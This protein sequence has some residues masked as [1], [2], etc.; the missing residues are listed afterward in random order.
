MTLGGRSAG[1][2]GAPADPSA[3]GGL[4]ARLVV[5]R[6]SFLLDIE[7]SVA[8]GEVVA[9]LG[10]NG[11]GKTTAL[12]ALAG[13]T[14]L[15]SGRVE[16]AGVCLDDGDRIF[17]PAERRSVGV[18]FQDYLLFPHLS[19]LENVAFGPRCRGAT[20]VASRATAQAWLSRVG[21][22][23]LARRRPRQLSGG[24]AQRV[25][26]ARALALEP[27][28]L[29]LDEPLA[30]LDARTR[31]DT[32]AEL[33]RHLAEHP[34]P[35]LVVTHEPLDAFVLADRLVI[36]EDGRIVQEGDAAEV[37]ARPRTDY[38]ARLVGLNLYRGR[39]DG[40]TVTLPTGTQLTAAD[41]V[42]GDAF[43]A[44]APAAVA[45][46]VEPPQGSP[47]NTWPARVVGVT[48]HGDNVRV[49]LGGGPG[50]ASADVTPAAAAALRLEPGQQVW[51]A[52]KAT[53]TRAYPA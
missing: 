48:R 35:T 4:H 28:L 19:A 45:L 40:H 12:R 17:V 3:N 1:G 32:R 42:A 33:H 38:V 21:L 49:R 37:T 27:A 16:L 41:T 18:V 22:G 43:V 24:Q 6:G 36:V 51:A 5:D 44:F 25:A 50:E 29:L 11:A 31:L 13:L 10:P 15:T 9:L 23:E 46:H 39:G 53:E 20:T 30:A 26:L 8:P 52:V 14:P 34:G 2:S 47:R 7:L